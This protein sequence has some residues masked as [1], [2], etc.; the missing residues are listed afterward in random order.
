MVEWLITFCWQSR[1]HKTCQHL[2]LR[3]GTRAFLLDAFARGW[4]FIV[5][6]YWSN[7]VLCY[8]RTAEQNWDVAVPGPRNS[9]DG[10]T[11]LL[12]RVLAVYNI[13]L[14]ENYFHYAA[15]CKPCRSFRWNVSLAYASDPG[16][17]TISSNY[18]ENIDGNADWITFDWNVMEQRMVNTVLRTNFTKLEETC[19]RAH[20][21]V[22]LSLIDKTDVAERT[23]FGFQCRK[24]ILKWG[25]SAN[26]LDALVKCR[27]W[28]FSGAFKQRG[29]KIWYSAFACARAGFQ[30]NI[31]YKPFQLW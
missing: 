21:V 1:I 17:T 24:N 19:F 26:W 18:F 9:N 8:R 10:R 6:L 23:V 12:E 29:F 27:I 7:P 30:K 20:I 14:L 22:P 28:P 31:L 3:L 4:L 11:C 13:W 2:F 5:V 15:L 16:T 25:V